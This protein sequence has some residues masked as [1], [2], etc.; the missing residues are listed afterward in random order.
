MLALKRLGCSALICKQRTEPCAPCST[1]HGTQ[2]GVGRGVFC[3][4]DSGGFVEPERGVSPGCSPLREGGGP[5][6][7]LPGPGG[8]QI[9]RSAREHK[10][11]PQ[12][13]GRDGP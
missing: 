1:S 5:V 7:R 9:W 13:R 2:A 11:H 8:C 4:T 3:G 10:L 6:C 12:L